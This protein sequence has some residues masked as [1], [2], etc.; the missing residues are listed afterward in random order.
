MMRNVRPPLRLDF[1][2]EDFEVFVNAP[3][4]HPP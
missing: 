2:F 1:R 4:G 3:G